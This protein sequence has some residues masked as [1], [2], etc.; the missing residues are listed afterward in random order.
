MAFSLFD[1]DGDGTI[2]TKELGSIFR[3]LG[4]NP[5]EEDLMKMVNDVD[6][7]GN[8]Y[9]D[10]DE[11]LGMMILLMKERDSNVEVHET[12]QIFDKNSDGFINHDELKS[13][14]LRLGEK[15]TDEEVTE[16]ILEADKDGDGQISY[17]EFAAMM[18]METK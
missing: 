10:F 17:E 18:A 13:V 3:S 7:D 15:L 8:G 5:S 1:K 11:F 14:M 4:Q 2:T 6:L 16:M 12:F 9:I